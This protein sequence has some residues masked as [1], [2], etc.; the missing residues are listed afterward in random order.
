[1]REPATP[2][3]LHDADGVSNRSRPAS[4]LA[5]LAALL[6]AH[7]ATANGPEVRDPD[8]FF[9]TPTFGDLAEEAAL[10]RDNDKLAMLLFFKS[11]SCQYC[12]YM[13]HKV[14]N[15]PEVQDWYRKH[16]V[17]IAVD[18]HGDVKLTDFDGITLPSKIFSD[19]RKVFVTPVMSFVD[20]AGNEIY[21]HL[22]M[23]RTPAEMLLLGEYIVERRYYDTEFRTF[24]RE[25][26][27]REQGV[28][29]TPGEESK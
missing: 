16:F 29:A 5:M 1:M 17:S 14:L 7:A 10:A 15:R 4:L 9:F 18:I 3:A 13:L 22:G 26:G 24:A 11:D 8:E 20:L 2:A 25:R 21:R 28:L 23:I 19:H 6:F 12:D 27:F